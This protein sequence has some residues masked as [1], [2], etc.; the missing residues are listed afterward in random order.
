MKPVSQQPRWYTSLFIVSVFA[1]VSVVSVGVNADNRSQDTTYYFLRHAE[2]DKQNP[3]KPLNP[4]G[5]KRAQALVAHFEGMPITH[6]YATHTDRTLDTVKPLS[7][8]WGISISQVPRQGQSLKGKT[9]TNRSK[10]K[11]AIKPML[12][13]LKAV[14]GGSQVVVSANSGNLFPIMAGLGVPLVGE[15]ACRNEPANCLPC[16]NKKCFPKKAFNNIWQVTL[17]ADGQVRLQRSRYG[18]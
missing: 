13:A 10:G 17:A 14:D 3:D 12:K 8:H 6:I 7:E 5:Q 2:F 18:D 11:V 4:K 1:F 9:V 16:K 15:E